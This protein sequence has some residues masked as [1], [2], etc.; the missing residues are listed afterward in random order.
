MH[1]MYYIQRWETLWISNDSL[2]LLDTLVLV[3][4]QTLAISREEKG[5]VNL[6]RI[7]GPGARTATAVLYNVKTNLR[8]DWL[9][10]FCGQFK[11]V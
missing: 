1:A 6:C 9:A 7:L 10:R 8:S 11:L 5:L 2:S 3:L 4:S